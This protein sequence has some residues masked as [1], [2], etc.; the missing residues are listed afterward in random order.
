VVSTL[1]GSG[2]AGYVNGTGAGAQFNNPFNV[3][4]DGSGN[5]IVPDYNNNRIRMITPAGVV[6]TIAGNGIG[7]FSDGVD[8]SASFWLP[9]G[10]AVGSNNDIFIGDNNNQR[11]RKITRGG[12]VTTSA[13]VAIGSTTTSLPS[14][15][16]IFNVGGPAWG[17]FTIKQSLIPSTLSFSQT[18][19]AGNT[20]ITTSNLG[21]W[22]SNASYYL[23]NIVLFNGSYY[24]NLAWPDARGPAYSGTYQASPTMD[25]NAWKPITLGTATSAQNSTT[26]AQAPTNPSLPVNYSLTLPGGMTNLS[27]RFE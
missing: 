27:I 6:T 2:T 13:P 9:F 10:V 17:Q 12:A 4:V 15:D 23:G 14:P 19:L 21:T 5:V 3:A 16:V 24:I 25:L 1:A 22:A 18:F 26:L 20:S 11:I 7:A 8:L